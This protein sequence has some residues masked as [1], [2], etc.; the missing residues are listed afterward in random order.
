MGVRLTPTAAYFDVDYRNIYLLLNHTS[1]ITI[2]AAA[3]CNPRYPNN[4]SYKKTPR[5]LFY[6]EYIEL[7]QMNVDYRIIELG[8]PVQSVKIYD[9]LWKKYA[10][11]TIV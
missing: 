8:S 2:L 9:N 1:Y 4:S 10:I 6:E 7:F 5:V 3:P 11:F